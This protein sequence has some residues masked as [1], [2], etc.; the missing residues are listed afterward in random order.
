M[1]LILAA[2]EKYI[3]KQPWQIKSSAF[4]DVLNRDPE[5]IAVVT[6]VNENTNGIELANHHIIEKMT[7]VNFFKAV[8]KVT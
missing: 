5:S 1:S 8:A 7:L 4:F 3:D 6:Y 2:V